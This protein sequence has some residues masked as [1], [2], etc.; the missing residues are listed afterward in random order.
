M[1][2]S[3]TRKVY[4][5]RHLSIQYSDDTSQ[6]WDAS[7]S[8]NETRSRSG[9]DN[10]RWRDQVRRGSQAATSFEG[11]EEKIRASKSYLVQHGY[12]V[13]P[14]PYRF[15]ELNTRVENF[16][17][18]LPTNGFPEGLSE[19]LAN[20]RALELITK[21]IRDKQTTFQGG[22][23][24]G[25]LARSAALIANPA[26]ALRKGLGHYTQ[27]LLKRGPRAAKLSKRQAL[28][29]VRDTWLEYQLGW[30]PLLNE[31]D[32]AIQTLA[33]SKILSDPGFETVRAVGHDEV[34]TPTQMN[35]RLGSWSYP[36]WRVDHYNFTKVS[37][38]YIASVDVGSYVT[39]NP[40]RI[41]F[42]ATNWLPTLWELVPY[43]FVVDYFTNI[44]DIIS[45]CTLAKSSVRWMVKTVR[46][47][48]GSRLENWRPEILTGN[49]FA[50][51]SQGTA[52]P[53]KSSHTIKYVKRDPY[54]GTLVPDLSFSLP[55]SNTQWLNIA[56]LFDA[57]RQLKRYYR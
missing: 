35:R 26:Q 10:P 11:T 36:Y 20:N 19:T 21:K 5:N 37:V 27:T 7:W 49:N 53:G 6:E 8:Q 45:A 51:Y 48:S 57:R 41:G 29:M 25:E 40:R 15:M 33:E 17:S 28:T 23:F 18:G 4:G 52:L 50:A 22:T 42:A 43:S 2:E 54:Y 39:Y 14:N 56:A 30:A 13:T 34:V 12:M 38:R 16:Y 55:G 44:G 31:V 1:E 32:G 47:Q 9:S 46:K 24:V 3:S